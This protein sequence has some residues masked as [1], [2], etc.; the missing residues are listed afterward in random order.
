MPAGGAE[1]RLGTVGRVGRGGLPRGGDA[2]LGGVGEGVRAHRGG[3]RLKGAVRHRKH[4][5]VALHG[6]A[7]GEVGRDEVRG[8]GCVRVIEPRAQL[9]A[10]HGHGRLPDQHA[11]AAPRYAHGPRA[12]E[13][14]A[15][16]PHKGVGGVRLHCR[17]TGGLAELEDPGVAGGV[18]VEALVHEEYAPRV[19]VLVL[20]HH[21]QEGVAVEHVHE[22]EVG[23][24]GDRARWELHPVEGL[25]R[26]ASRMGVKVEVQAVGVARERE[27]HVE[28]GRVHLAGCDKRLSVDT[29]LNCEVLLCLD[30]V[31]EH[32]RFFERQHP[33]LLPLVGPV[34][35]LDTPHV[36]QIRAVVQRTAEDVHIA[37]VHSGGVLEP[38]GGIRHSQVAGEHA[39]P[40]GSVHGEAH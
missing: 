11:G 1:R 37:V 17:V 35:D 2:V 16:V 27:H 13:D 12:V 31:L 39:V 32:E 20:R 8:V 6:V 23:V 24:R 10:V 25:L 5:L 36:V 19:V 40:G 14:V 34:S 7:L 3:H 26:V 9:K 4:R 38:A 18:E 30:G 28:A 29:H 33:V 21:T 15:A 22:L